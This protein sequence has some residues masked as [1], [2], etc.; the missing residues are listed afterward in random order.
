MVRC[1]HLL[2][3]VLAACSTPMETRGEGAA[4][5]PT[6]VCDAPLVCV[7]GACAARPDAYIV[8]DA[9]LPPQVIVDIV[10]VVTP[11]V[12]DTERDVVVDS[13]APDEVGSELRVLLGPHD[14]LVDPS[15]TR[16]G[17]AGGQAAAREVV[18]P[19]P[20]EVIGV[21]AVVSAPEGTSGACALYDVAL[22]VDDPL[23]G[24]PVA[25]TFRSTAF[26]VSASTEPVRLDL[27]ER[28]MVPAGR[29]RFGLVYGGPCEQSFPPWLAL[30]ASGDASDTFVWANV[31]IP[32]ASLSLD[33]R[34]GLSLAVALQVR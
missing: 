11:E 8:P 19:G 29:L 14:A 4:C 1:H 26:H 27:A 33:G 10:D 32:G 13:D 16:L 6:L 23:T 9:E 12:E 7:D 3:L 34:W 5:D 17:L 22:W 25:P 15:D 24:F 21:E 2:V 28:V 31:W 20:A 30:D 18:V